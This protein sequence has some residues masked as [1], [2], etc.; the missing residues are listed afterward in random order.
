MPPLL[1]LG[2]SVLVEG[3]PSVAIANIAFPNTASLGRS[4]PTF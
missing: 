4:I 1:G 3:S 2:E